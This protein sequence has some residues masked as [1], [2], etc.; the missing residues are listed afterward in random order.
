MSKGSAITDG[1][2]QVRKVWMTQMERKTAQNAFKMST[3]TAG[4]AIYKDSLYGNLYVIP[5]CYVESGI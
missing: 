3:V 2:S 1:A 4:T 5:I